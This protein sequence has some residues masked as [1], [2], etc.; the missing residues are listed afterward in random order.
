MWLFVLPV[1]VVALS[2]VAAHWSG[3]ILPDGYSARWFSRLSS[4]DLDALTTSLQVGFGVV[5]LGTLLGLWLALA[6]EG[7]DRRGIGA[8]VDM[9]AM[10]GNGVPSVVLG[11]AVLIA[12]HKRS[13]SISQGRRPS[14]CWCSSRSC[15]RSAIAAPPPRS[16]PN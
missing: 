5:V 11:L 1:G 12:Y 15:C 6:L 16:G 9:V 10:P 7:R 4:S 8:V 3:T 13:R 14:S 2:S